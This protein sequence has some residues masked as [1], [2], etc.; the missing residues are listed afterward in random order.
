[1]RDSAAD[2]GEPPVLFLYY[3][4]ACGSDSPAHQR[5]VAAMKGIEAAQNA[6]TYG[7]EVAADLL[8]V[9]RTSDSRLD[10]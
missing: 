6:T 2:T 5:A 4:E 8:Q 1:M 10:F 3:Q 7:G 9:Q